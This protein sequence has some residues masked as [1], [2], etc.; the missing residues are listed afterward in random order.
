MRKKKCVGRAKGLKKEITSE[1]TTIINEVAAHQSASQSINHSF[2]Q[3]VC[4]LIA[5]MCLRNLV[6]I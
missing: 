6:G 1:Q 5:I 3:L 4:R 2:N